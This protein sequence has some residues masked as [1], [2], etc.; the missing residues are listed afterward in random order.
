MVYMVSQKVLN[1]RE[2]SHNQST[3]RQPALL[4]TSWLKIESTVMW[5]NQYQNKQ[6]ANY[7]LLELKT[8]TYLQHGETK[9][10][11]KKKGGK[12]PTKAKQS[13]SKG[14]HPCSSQKW[15]A[16]DGSDNNRS[17]EEYEVHS[18]QSHKK[19]KCAVE[20]EEVEDNDES[21]KIEE[22]YQVRWQW[23]WWVWKWGW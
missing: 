16:S 12:Q 13:H 7:F 19:A 3:T 4:S 22:S 2:T 11:S 6:R 8:L 10:S 1:H 15:P 9:A 14:Q 20:V 21:D 17:N 5:S 18:A 23:V